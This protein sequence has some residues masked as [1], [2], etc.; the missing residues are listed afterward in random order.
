VAL[1]QIVFF[2]L[3]AEIFEI[4]LF[5]RLNFCERKWEFFCNIQEYIYIFQNENFKINNHLVNMCWNCPC[6]RG[7]AW[8]YIIISMDILN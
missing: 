7:L 3:N 5:Q 4:Y 1:A 8:N 6:T 2:F